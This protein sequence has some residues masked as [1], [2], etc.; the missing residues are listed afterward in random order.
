MSFTPKYQKG[1]NVSLTV[2]ATINSGNDV[3]WKWDKDG[4]FFSINAACLVDT[5][6]DHSMLAL[7]RP[8]SLLGC[9]VSYG[10]WPS[11]TYPSNGN[12]VAEVMSGSVSYSSIITEKLAS[13]VTLEFQ[14][15]N[16][17]GAYSIYF[18]EHNDAAEMCSLQDGGGVGV[19]GLSIAN[20]PSAGAGGSLFISGWINNVAQTFSGL[21][22]SVLSTPVNTSDIWK[23]VI[24]NSGVLKIYKNA[25]LLTT[26]SGTWTGSY[27]VGVFYDGPYVNG[28]SKITVTKFGH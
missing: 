11:I 18:T 20:D 15:N 2:P 7:Y 21:G 23:I 12:I 26:A 19:T 28:H 10:A 25:V 5:D 4:V 24:D 27:L 3:F 13:P 17:A 22:G 6:D 14:F 8:N 16:I 9:P 1:N